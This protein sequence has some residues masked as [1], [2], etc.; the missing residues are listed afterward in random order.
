MTEEKPQK[1]QQLNISEINK[2]ELL[3]SIEAIL[4]VWGEPICVKR[5][6]ELIQV[7]KYLVQEAIDQLDRIYQERARGIKII[8]ADDNYL[9]GTKPEF[10]YLMERLFGNS[11]H[12]GLSNAS[13]EVLSIVALRQPITR[14]QIDEIRGVNCSQLLANLV[15]RELVSV[16]GKADT[17][18]KPQTYGTT[19]KFLQ[20]FGINSLDDLPSFHDM[21][22][23]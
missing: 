6:S 23:L 14:A 10:S 2:E 19:A 5:L 16:V 8:K 11:R 20:V 13:L 22:I 12:R 9:L 21:E 7:D 18:F 17:T 15:E 3:A 4:F 1:T